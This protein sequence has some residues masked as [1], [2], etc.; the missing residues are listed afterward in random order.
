LLLVPEPTFTGIEKKLKNPQD[1]PNDQ[2]KRAEEI[3][4]AHFEQTEKVLSNLKATQLVVLQDLDSVKRKIEEG[5]M[6]A[7]LLDNYK[8]RVERLTQINELQVSKINKVLSSQLAFCEICEVKSAELQDRNFKEL[9]VGEQHA[10][11]TQG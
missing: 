3:V 11:P 6:P 9:A 4:Y 7:I 1:T 2:R 10:Q 8:H 5:K